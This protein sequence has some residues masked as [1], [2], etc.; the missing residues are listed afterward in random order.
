M[1][2]KIISTWFGVVVEIVVEESNGFI[3][4]KFEPISGRI[5]S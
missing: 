4:Y 3:G 1:P 2:N 5:T